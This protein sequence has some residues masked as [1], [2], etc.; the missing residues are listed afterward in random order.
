MYQYPDQLIAARTAS[1][2]IYYPA[3]I[4]RHMAC[5]MWYVIE[6]GANLSN[7][8]GLTPKIVSSVLQKNVDGA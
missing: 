8:K 4:S 5:G 1:A 7:E 2:A 6:G 3:I